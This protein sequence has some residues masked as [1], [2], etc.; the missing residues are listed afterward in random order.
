MDCRDGMTLKECEGWY[1]C[2]FDS[3]RKLKRRKKNFPEELIRHYYFQMDDM[4]VSVSDMATSSED[5]E[6]MISDF[7]KENED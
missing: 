3:Y 4:Y 7:N 5:V 2:D 6:K 1:C